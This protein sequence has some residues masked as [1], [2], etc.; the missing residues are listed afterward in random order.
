MFALGG[1]DPPALNPPAEL[2]PP[3]PAP[4]PPGESRPTRI[5]P[6]LRTPRSSPSPIKPSIPALQPI[7]SDEAPPA[8]IGP[9]E[10]RPA[11]A[12]PTPR[13][14][15]SGDVPSAS[16][17]RSLFLESVPV[18]DSDALP[19]AS[20]RPGAPFAAPETSRGG[21]DA[22]GS[23]RRPRFFGLFSTP[24]APRQRGSAERGDGIAVEPRDD[25]AADAAIKRRI[26]RQIRDSVG[27]RLR[28]VD[29]S[30]V[31][32]NVIIRARVTR[33]WHRRSVRRTLD[34]LPGLAGYKT[35]IEVVD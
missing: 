32:R 13:P 27:D 1:D 19:R 4:V 17:S 26:E 18:G 24:S 30:V 29:V 35:R 11:D 3:A 20:S 12:A 6:G 33:F 31:D 34:A 25:P 8:L 16:G 9:A 5:A 21:D 28:S 14:R 15:Y 7:D 23:S 2:P 10:M 22:F